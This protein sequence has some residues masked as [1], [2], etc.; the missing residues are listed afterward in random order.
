[1]SRWPVSRCS[2]EGDRRMQLARMAHNKEGQHEEFVL[3]FF[4]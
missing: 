4:R 1:M 3:A 2:A